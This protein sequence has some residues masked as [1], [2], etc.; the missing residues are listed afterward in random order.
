MARAGLD[1][2]GTQQSLTQRGAQSM[3]KKSTKEIFAETLLALSRSTPIEKITVKQIVEGSGLSLQ[4]FYNHFRDKNDLVRWIHRSEGE[5][6]LARLEGKRYRFHDLTM[7]NVRFYSQNA[8]YL[9]NSMGGGLL[10]PYAEFSAESAISFLTSYICSRRSLE[11][12]PKQIEFFLRMFVYACL[13]AFADWALGDASLTEEELAA[14]L[15][16]GMP[17]KL[18]PYLLD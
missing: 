1:G 2:W 14:Y 16:D 9:R 11:R 8:N 7:D 6:A 5:R 17:E 18:K 10:N 15:E 3:K 12:L 4:T 13:H